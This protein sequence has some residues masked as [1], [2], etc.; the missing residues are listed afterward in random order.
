M[1]WARD[2][3]VLSEWLFYTLSISQQRK[4]LGLLVASASAFFFVSAFAFFFVSAFAFFFVS[5]FAFFFVSAFA[6]FATCRSISGS[7]GSRIS[8]CHI[9][10]SHISACH[11]A[12]SHISACH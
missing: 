1:L 8:A 6:F 4:K 3:A 2:W 9:A 12:S 10:S 5:A 11:I 7:S